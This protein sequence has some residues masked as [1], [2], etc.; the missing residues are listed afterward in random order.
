MGKQSIGESIVALAVREQ[1]PAAVVM[2]GQAQHGR[3]AAAAAAP[4]KTGPFLAP[5]AVMELERLTNQ[6]IRTKIYV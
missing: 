3:A 2:T 6:Q 4:G 5:L 1:H